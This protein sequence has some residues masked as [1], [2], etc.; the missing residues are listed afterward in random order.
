MLYSNY[1]HKTCL[2][3]LFLCIFPLITIVLTIS[4]TIK[5]RLFAR[6]EWLTK[7]N[8][9]ILISLR[10]RGRATSADI[11]CWYKSIAA[12]F[13]KCVLTKFQVNIKSQILKY[14]NRGFLYQIGRWIM[15]YS[16][17][18]HKTSFIFNIKFMFCICFIITIDLIFIDFRFIHFCLEI[19]QWH[20]NVRFLPPISYV[21]MKQTLPL[22][23]W[24]L[25]Y[26]IF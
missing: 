17:Y 3:L 8:E 18:F 25:N 22:P 6:K 14:T 15:L 24:P 19:C 12:N 23:N 21:P 13:C 10:S 20:L 5:R 9:A 2:F 7:R 1:F 11:I 26:V 4:F 16:N